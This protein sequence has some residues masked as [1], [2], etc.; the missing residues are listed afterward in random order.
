MKTKTLVILG[1]MGVFAAG[2]YWALMQEV[3]RETAK[4]SASVSGVVDVTHE[5][6]ARGLGDVNKQDHLLVLLVD[7]ATGRPVASHMESILVPP[8]SFVVG[9]QEAMGDFDP[10]GRYYVVAITDKDGNGMQPAPGELYGRTA[11]P[12]PLGTQEIQLM[13]DRPFR[14]KLLDGL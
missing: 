1:G 3:N 9:Q 4:F 5:V 14:G 12:V 6:L 13:L 10:Q 8:Q 11:Q 7:P 2:L